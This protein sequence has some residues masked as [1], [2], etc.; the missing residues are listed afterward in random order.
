LALQQ[1]A[2][3]VRLDKVGEEIKKRRFTGAIGANQTRNT[4]PLDG[5]IR[6]IH[7][8][9][10]AKIFTEALSGLALLKRRG[11]F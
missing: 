4:S 5:N 7:R 8:L 6:M 1:N 11:L 3:L 10:T 2:A 9:E